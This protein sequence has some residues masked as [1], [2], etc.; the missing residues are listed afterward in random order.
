MF[1][2]C[3]KCKSLEDEVKNLRETNQKLIDRLTAI[4]NPKAFASVHMAETYKPP[5][6]DDDDVD[7][8]IEIQERR[9]TCCYN[10]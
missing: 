4:V 6:Q 7:F 9:E 1:M 3:K 10:L 8:S 5:V 2:S